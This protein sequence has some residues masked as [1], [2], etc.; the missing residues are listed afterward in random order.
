MFKLGCDGYTVCGYVGQLPLI[1]DSLVK[2]ARLHDDFGVKGNDGTAL[3]VTVG[4]AG[5]KWPELV[6]T[7]RIDPG[8]ESGFFPG[9]LIVPDHQLVLIGGGTRLLA[10]DFAGPRRLWHDTADTGFWGWSRHG[11]TILMSAELEFAAWDSRGSKL[12]ATFVEPPWDYEVHEG[13]VDLDVMGTRSSFDIR[14][15]PK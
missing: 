4:R 6:V 2:H 10:Y 14:T 5:A 12:W 7:Q 13:R 9:G 15:G 8:P 1:Y 11:D 3:C